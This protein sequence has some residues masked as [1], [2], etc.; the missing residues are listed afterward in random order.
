MA[1]EPD[2]YST[3]FPGFYLVGQVLTALGV[4][5]LALCA[6]FR[7][8][9]PL[10]SLASPKAYHDLGNLLWAFVILWAY[11]E[12]SQLVITWSGNL[13]KEIVWYLHRTSGNWAWITAFLA[14]FHFARAVL[15]SARPQEQAAALRRLAKIAGFVVVVHCVEQYWNVE[16]A[17]HPEGIF[18]SWLDFAAPH[19][20]GRP[21]G[22]AVPEDSLHSGRWCRCND[23]RL[24]RSVGESRMSRAPRQHRAASRRPDAIEHKDVNP[25]GVFD[26]PGRTARPCWA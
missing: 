20:R 22:G 13:P 4:A 26:F 15:H 8:Q 6:M 14:L 25:D 3:M 5:I 1:L 12:V 18:V 7:A 9:G 10:A 21:V 19:R 11:V 24:G 23:P 2:W 16:P 17:F